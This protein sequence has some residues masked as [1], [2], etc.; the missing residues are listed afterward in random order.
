MARECAQVRTNSTGVINCPPENKRPIYIS[1]MDFFLHSGKKVK[2]MKSGKK[3][4]HVQT[5]FYQQ[6]FLILIYRKTGI[7]SRGL[8]L[9]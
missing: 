1:N 9:F 2:E 3:Y 8:Y 7:R 5:R 4:R 6:T